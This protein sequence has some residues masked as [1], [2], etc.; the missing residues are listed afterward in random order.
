MYNGGY[1]NNIYQRSIDL[2][3]ETYFSR[4]D[5]KIEQPRM[6]YRTSSYVSMFDFGIKRPNYFGIN[7]LERYLIGLAGRMQVESTYLTNSS[8][9]NAS[10]AYVPFFMTSGEIHN[11]VIFINDGINS[12]DIVSTLSHELSKAVNQIFRLTMGFD[13]PKNIAI[14][15]LSS[16]ELKE[17]HSMHS[18]NWNEEIVGFAL[19]MKHK[20]ETSSVFIRESPIEHL[21]L[22]IGHEIGHCL[23]IAK[24]DAKIEEAKAFAF[25]LAWMETIHRFNILG[26]KDSMKISLLSPSVNGLHN[27]ALDF[28]RSKLWEN[29]PLEVFRKIVNDELNLSG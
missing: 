16:N 11:P 24:E 21:L 22:T 1:V 5:Y 26:L 4:S 10:Q 2:D 20:N 6:F 28:V 7:A 18:K 3:I 14:S 9:Y 19:N 8:K 25:E 12:K 23:S 29:T 13:L 15:I 17:V 27:V